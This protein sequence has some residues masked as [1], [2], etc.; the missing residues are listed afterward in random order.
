VTDLGTEF[1][2]E[3]TREGRTDAAVFRGAIRVATAGGGG[4]RDSEHVCREGEAVRVEAGKPVVRT[5]SRGEKNAGNF[6]RAMPSGNAIDSQAYAE[7]V[8]SLKPVVYYRME[9]AGSEKDRFV[10]FDS[11]PGGHH[12][13][14]R[15][16]NEFGGPPYRPGRFGDS[17]WLRGAEAGDRVFVP[18][19]PKAAHGRLTVSAWVMAMNRPNWAMIAS[20]WGVP[21][22]NTA[23]TGQFHLGL[24]P[25]DGD[26]AA[27]VTQRSGRWVEVREG[28]SHPLPMFVWQHVALVADGKNLHLYRN[29]REV[30]SAACA[31]VLFPPPVASLGIG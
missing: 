24:Y 3:V 4:N 30:D 11:A 13:E 23:T 5:L 7:L 21:V 28:A 27:R 16:G 10:V 20:N 9:Q 17:I 2:V 8:L 14:L 22:P 25:D 19:Y 15:L 1:G 31:G 12:G 26:L 6:V 18:D 29:G